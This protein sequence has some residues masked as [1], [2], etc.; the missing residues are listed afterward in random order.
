MRIHVFG[1]YAP[2]GFSSS[3]V[4][5]KRKNGCCA[6]GILSLILMAQFLLMSFPGAIKRLFDTAVDD[7]YTRLIKPKVTR[8]YR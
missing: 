1:R 6:V 5:V 2:F 4:N 3:S 8:Q 7:S